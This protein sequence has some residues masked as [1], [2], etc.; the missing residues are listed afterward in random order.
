LPVRF[1]D[2]SFCIGPANPKVSYLNLANIISA[3]EVLKADAIHP[4][5]DF[6]SE[7]ANF[8]KVC[9]ECGITFIGAPPECLKTFGDKVLS[10]KIAQKIGIPVIPGTTFSL[11]NQESA[12]KIADEIGYPVVLKASS[13]GGGRGIRIVQNKEELKKNFLQ[14]QEE[15]KN[16]FG[17]TEI[18]IE[19]YLEAPRH[20]EIQF[21]GDKRGNKIYFGERDCSLQ[22][23]N[24]KILEEAPAVGISDKMR[25]EMGES[26]VSLMKEVN[27]DNVGTVEFLVDKKKKFYF[28]EVNP[29]I[30]VEHPVSEMVMGVDLVKLQILISMGYKLN[31]S[32]KQ[33][34]P[35]GHSIQARINA[36]EPERNFIPS[37]GTIKKVILPGGPGIRVDTYIYEDYTVLPY[38]DSLI[39][40]LICWGKDRE[41]AILR[42][43]RALYEFKVDGIKT[44][45]PFF[46]KILEQEQFLKGGIDTNFLKEFKI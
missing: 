5:Y 25:K 36:E 17:K 27:Y 11:K 19:K 14:T 34:R 2:E 39:A 3:A 37:P 29:R 6:L 16:S 42:L 12:V 35:R 21:V 46:K 43:N 8:A 38:Y 20:I 32:Q 40:K 30:Q 41:E 18:Y 4:G 45:I 26:A 22:R 13:G 23:R 15:V 28:L 9:E 33:T 1:A 24:Q 10:R 7:D 44:T 31:I